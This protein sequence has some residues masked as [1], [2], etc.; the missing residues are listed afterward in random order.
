MVVDHLAA[1]FGTENIGVASVYLNH[2]EA[3]GQT[4]PKLFS[5]LWRQLVLRRD[6]GPL[7]KQ[8]YYQHHE[9]GT[10][11]SVNEV[12][13]VL[14]AAIGDYLK[15]YIIVDAIDEYPEAQRQIL[16][17]YLMMME[18]TVNLMITSRPHIRPDGSLPILEAL[19][20]RA[21][22]DDIRR[23]VEGQ[24][25]KSSW[26]SKHVQT[27][28]DLRDEILSTITSNVDG[29]FLLAKLHIESLSKKST[30]KRVREALKTLPKDLNDSYDSAMKRIEDQNMEERTIAHSALTWVVNA[31]RP[32]TVAELQAAL[33][34][35][36]G[37]QELD[38]DNIL[39][40]EI[41]LAV[42]A[43]LV[44]VDEQL[45]VGGFYGNALQ[46]ASS[47]GHINTVQGGRYANALQAASF[48]GHIY[49]VQLLIEHGADVNAVGGFYGN[50]LQAAS[51]WGHINT[52]QLLIK[53][54]AD[55]NA[56][57]GCYTNALQAAS[58]GG[59]IN[60][61]QML[62]EHSANV[63]AQGGRFGNAL[64]AASFNGR[65]NI[66][67]LLI[68]HS[69][70]VNAQ[71]GEYGNA[72]QAASSNGHINIVQLL[73]E[74][75]AEVNAQGGEYGNAL[76]AASSNG[77]INIVQLLIEHSAEVNAQGGEYGNALQAASYSGHIDIGGEYG[78]ALQ[79]ASSEGH[80]HIVQLLI[81]HSANVNAQGERFG[82]ALQAASF[83]GHRD[84]V[85]LLIEHGANVNVHGGEYGSALQAASFSGY[86]D[87][88]QLLIQHG[89]DVHAQGGKYG[90]AL[91]AA[92]DYEPDDNVE[93]IQRL[94]TVAQLLRDNGAHEEDPD[95]LQD[96]AV[97]AH[98]QQFTDNSNSNSPI[99]P[100]AIALSSPA[101]PKPSFVRR[102]KSSMPRAE[103]VSI[104]LR[105]AVDPAS[106]LRVLLLAPLLALP[107]H[108]LL[109]LLPYLPLSN[110]SPQP[111]FTPFF[112]FSHPT[113]APERFSSAVVRPELVLTTQLYL[114]YL[115][116]LALLAYS[117]VLF[118]FFRLVMSHSLF[119]MLARR[120]GIRKAGKVARLCGGLS[121]GGGHLGVP[122]LLR[123]KP[124]TPNFW[125]GRRW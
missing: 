70:D 13:N 107:T 124:R 109:L 44:I 9:K 2:K 12:F 18:S 110:L 43:G 36:P 6:L 10:S 113:T 4:P 76:Q 53:H 14:Q 17:E 119:P 16:L 1:E 84:I 23:Y 105:W 67:Q 48:G 59:H 41:I 40:I 26:L 118:S 28:A 22:E 21:N 31:K 117:V 99:L 29:M 27:R 46:A 32:L 39:D 81:E 83:N 54:G 45:S 94:E 85:Q 50:P 33:A 68:E 8:L 82:N 7:A 88:I 51:S 61:V 11:P 35:E 64:Q 80:I 89:A 20:I 42:C 91:K 49:T 101:Y 47:G 62:I 114:K 3:E 86:I 125:P 102:P 116:G 77:H 38:D 65:I 111:T 123:A 37:A 72:L 92:L 5:G 15:V 25:Q 24:I 90:N 71:G 74:H 112:L 63:N 19:E 78:N 120:W 34:V 122:R 79:E 98:G 121:F 106:A 96:N 103:D 87:I 73:I 69:A 30:I 100:P 75:S 55:V 52:V 66:V 93:L 58:S 108:F 104:W 95:A 56:Q 115:G 60:T 57:G 97:S